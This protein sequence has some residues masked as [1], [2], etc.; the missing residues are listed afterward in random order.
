MCVLLLTEKSSGQIFR[1][2][3]P[4]TTAGN[5]F[6]ASVGIDGS[7]AV[8]G[9]SGDNG[10]GENSGAAF[11]YE[12]GSD[13]E[14]SETARLEPDDCQEGL[15]FGKTVAASGNRVVVA[16]YIPF[17]STV[18]SNSVYVFERDPESSAWRQTARIRQPTQKE[19]G[20]FAASV[21]LSG[22]RLLIT[23]AGD[24]S[25]GTFG[26]TAYIYDYD[27]SSWINTARL[28]GSLG[29]EYG[30]FGTSAALDGDRAVVSASTYLAHQPGSLFV[31]DRTPE[32][33]VWRETAVLSGIEDFFISV[34]LDGGRILV[35]ESKGGR[36]NTGRARVFD[37][38]RDG[39]WI[40]VASLEPS[41]KFSQGGFGSLVSLSGDHALVVGFDEQLR[42]EF[43]IDRVVYLFERGPSGRWYQ[44]HIIDVGEVAF[45]SAVDL[46]RG[47]AIIGQA[48]DQ[49][50]GQAFVVLIR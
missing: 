4:D 37:L 21:A 8:V 29:T 42:F 43:N 16:A 11:V 31:Y 3:P 36:R 40:S 24:A 33:G 32:T 20:P 28:K 49:L 39:R 5:Y 27:G 44:K 19:E 45:G 9:A 2:P 48:S 22:D 23:T 10:C 7:I 13:E 18:R 41:T 35:G 17:F 15:F 12:I 34:D 6:G 46:N 14:W 1:L 30:I 25:R 47:K 38:D 50:P 26:G